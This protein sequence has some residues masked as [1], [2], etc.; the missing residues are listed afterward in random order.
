MKI[1]TSVTGDLKASL[2]SQT[3]REIRKELEHTST[4]ALEELES[5]TP[6]DTG[7]AASSWEVVFSGLKEFKLFNDTPYIGALNAGHSRQAPSFF[8][9]NESL[10]FG[11]AN[12]VIV[13]Y[14]N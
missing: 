4:K 8:I 6:K 1:R 10:K 7:L 13:E 12:G 2:E 9:E 5:A 14:Q 3:S 11:R